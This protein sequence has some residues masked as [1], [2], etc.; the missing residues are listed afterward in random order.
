MFPEDV[1][2]RFEWLEYLE[3]QLRD[4]DKFEKESMKKNIKVKEEVWK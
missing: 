4:I 1:K 3:K 2:R